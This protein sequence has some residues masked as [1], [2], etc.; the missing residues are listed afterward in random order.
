MNNYTDKQLRN[1]KGLVSMTDNEFFEKF[2]SDMT[3]EEQMKFVELCPE[4]AEYVKSD[5]MSN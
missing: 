4:L 3:L 5:N 2:V 1:I